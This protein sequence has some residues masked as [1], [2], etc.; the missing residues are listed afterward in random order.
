MDMGA[1]FQN[2]NWL[3][4]LAATLS[5]FIIGG[6]WYSPLMCG[7]V[8]MEVTGITDE[9]M[10][11]SNKGKIFGLAFVLILISA[12]DLGMFL[13]PTATLAAGIAAGSAA[14]IGWVATAFGV[15]YLFELR[16]G[17]HLA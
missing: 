13:G 10:K 12:I 9:Q 3:A 11:A 2:L 15:V 1:A 4:V 17:R 8:W 14:A 5:T 7:K 16:P 6:V